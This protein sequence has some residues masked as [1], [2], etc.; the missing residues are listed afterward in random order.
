MWCCS[1]SKRGSPAYYLAA[2]TGMRRGEVLGLRWRDVDLDTRRLSVHQA[3]ISVA[4]ALQVAD[5]KTGTSRRTIDLD[6]RT[7][8][9]LR[10]WRKRQLERA[11]RLRS[12]PT[13]AT[14]CRSVRWK[15]R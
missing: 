1:P 2:N 3:A 8:A 7:V 15:T 11:D 4:Y 12:G 13:R 9:V 10:S 14:H 5:V 6:P